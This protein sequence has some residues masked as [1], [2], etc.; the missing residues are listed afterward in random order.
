MET[1]SAYMRW[2]TANLYAFPLAF[3]VLWRNDDA[4]WD[5]ARALEAVCRDKVHVGLIRGG[6]RSGKTYAGKELCAAMALGG[7][8]PAVKVW[9]SDNGLPEDMIPPG[10]GVCVMV[11][12]SA[13]DSVRY[14]REDVGRMLPPE[15]VYWYNKNAH[16][17]ARVYIDV[18]GYDRQ[19]VIYFK[20]VDQGHRKYKGMQCRY[21]DID[22]EPEGL[23]GKLVFDECLRATAAEG[24]LVVLTMTPQS[25]QTWVYQ[26]IEK[27]GKH[28]S[29]VIELDA[30]HNTTVKD[31]DAL[32]AWLDALDDDQKEMRRFG[33]FVHREGLVYPMFV[34]GDSSRY[35][36]G[37]MCEPFDI[38]EDWL[39]FRSADFGLSLPTVVLWGAVGDDNTLYIYRGHYMG[40]ISYE[41]HAER[42]HELQ[43][44][45]KTDGKWVDGEPIE[46]SWGDPGDT[47][48]EAM[49][50]WAEEDLYFSN[51]TKHVKE[52]ISRVIERMTLRP[53][54]RPRL[55]V[56]TSVPKFV[57]EI[58]AYRWNPKMLVPAPIKRHD[59]V[60]DALRYL[61]MGIA[62][63][64]L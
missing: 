43:G 35:G 22:E 48:K 24:G 55:K 60:M 21:I 14:H 44:D 34:R 54:K 30:L 23:E 62:E 8:H 61:C 5:Q 9:L 64:G 36:P 11:A 37:H 38:P 16:M 26:D 25:G 41:A 13:A 42:I 19:G 52:G 40:G 45:V 46:A 47:G 33:R 29:V 20:S 49:R 15:G 63:Y 31:R 59:H 27:A 1:A 58:E 7:D 18:P 50:I 57:D 51:A 39:R 56:F 53:D 17:E 10:P 4:P 6:N 12:Q 2:Y 3:E 32:A 28:N